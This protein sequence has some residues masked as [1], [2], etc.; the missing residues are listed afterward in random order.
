MITPI[1]TKVLAKPFPSD[2]K[3]A[4]GIIVSDA[5][6]AVSNKMKVISVGRGT[7]K[8]P[9]RFKKDDVVF[10][11]KDHGDEIIIGG[12]KYYLIEQSH[13]IAKMN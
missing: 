9:M 8:D 3:S 12:E 6:K 13:L 4:G 7:L 10:R 5:H 1:R 11:V 2:D